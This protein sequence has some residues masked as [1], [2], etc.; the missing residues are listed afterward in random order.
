MGQG[1]VILYT[2]EKNILDIHQDLNMRAQ[3][4]LGLK[5]MFPGRNLLSFWVGQNERAV[6]YRSNTMTCMMTLRLAFASKT[7][8]KCGNKGE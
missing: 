6:D 7:T 3:R 5:V 1:P 8:E 2:A 4:Q